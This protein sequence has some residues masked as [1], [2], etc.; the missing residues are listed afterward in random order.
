MAP[1]TPEI[2]AEMKTRIAKRLER[3]GLDPG[4]E[5]YNACYTKALEKIDPRGIPPSVVEAELLKPGSTNVRVVRV[6]KGTGEE[7]VVTVMPRK[8]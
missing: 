3:M 2:R 6:R 7:I 1:D 5:A 4:S 8:K